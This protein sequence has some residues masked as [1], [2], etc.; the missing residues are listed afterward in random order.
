MSSVIHYRFKAGSS[1][2]ARIQFEGHATTLG[3][4]KRAI[5]DQKKLNP[6]Q[7]SAMAGAGGGEGEGA[8]RGGGGGRMLQDFELI[9]TNADTNEEYQGDMTPIAKN[10][11]VI[12]KRVPSHR[13]KIIRIEASVTRRVIEAVGA[14]LDSCRITVKQL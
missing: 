9:I 8:G 12:V 5:A 10:S 3:E 7:Q 6:T 13:S 2:W 14:A 11:S 4:L 1:E